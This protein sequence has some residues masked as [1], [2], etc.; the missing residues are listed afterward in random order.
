METNLTRLNEADISHFSDP[1]NYSPTSKIQPQYIG[2][3]AYEINALYQLEGGHF[4][5][6]ASALVSFTRAAKSIKTQSR[7]LTN[8]PATQS[9]PRLHFFSSNFYRKSFTMSILGSI[10][11]FLYMAGSA[12]VFARPNMAAEVAPFTSE[13]VHQMAA[14]CI[15]PSI[16]KATDGT[17]ATIV[18]DDMVA[19]SGRRAKTGAD[20]SKTCHFDVTVP[21]SAGTQVGVREVSIRGYTNMTKDATSELKATFNFDGKAPTVN[22]PVSD[23]CGYSSRPS[24]DLDID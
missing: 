14:K 5:Q 7:P 19:E 1:Y 24:L 15:P 22:T 21:V 9:N 23:N 6:G 20:A 10:V 8:P 4:I 18:F 17:A 13:L 2:A 11:F 12:P 3:F 16:V